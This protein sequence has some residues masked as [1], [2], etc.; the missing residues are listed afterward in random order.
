M[1]LDPHAPFATHHFELTGEVVPLIK[2]GGPASGHVATRPMGGWLMTYGKLTD[3]GVLVPTVDRDKQIIEAARELG[4]IDWSPYLENG[5]WNDTHDES[6]IVGVPETLSFHDES[7]EMAQAHR[8]VGFWTTGHLWDR[9]DPQSW[10]AY[11]DCSRWAD[12][13]PSERELAQA[14]HFWNLAN[15]LQ[16]LPRPLAL[17]AHGEMALSPCNSRVIWCRVRQAAVCELPKNPDATLE[18]MAKGA[19]LFELRKGM[20][21]R[22]PCGRCT[23]PP[24]A[25]DGLLRKAGGLGS[26]TEGAASPQDGQDPDLMDQGGRRPDLE[27]LIDIIVE[28][29]FVDRNTAERWVAQYYRHTRRADHGRG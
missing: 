8:K 29:Y 27:T 21:G 7:S 2:S 22:N 3:G 23:C 14:D 15:L 19:R 6:V 10:E 25:C 24:W 4:H 11:V 18:I 9:N 13:R 16:G 12:G 20:V 28:Q 26:Q 1:S 17:S 5:L